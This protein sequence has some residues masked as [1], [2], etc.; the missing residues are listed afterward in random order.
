VIARIRSLGALDHQSKSPPNQV[1]IPHGRSCLILYQERLG[2][3]FEGARSVAASEVARAAASAAR[4]V[5]RP[6][7]AVATPG[8]VGA[9]VRVAT[10]TARAASAFGP[11]G[12]GEGLA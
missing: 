1:I 10:P 6:S 9:T 7:P 4:E 2:T 5:A 12:E 8:L 11:V 3:T